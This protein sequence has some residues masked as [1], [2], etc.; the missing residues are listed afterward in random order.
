MPAGEVDFIALKRKTLVFVEVKARSVS[1]DLY[2]SYG[3]PASAVDRQ[4]QK[5]TVK[6]A[7]AYISTCKRRDAAKQPR[8]DVLEVWLN[9]DHKVIDINHITNAYC[10][11]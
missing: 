4:K 7:Q 2:L 9:E 8:M 3:S 6:A 5:R 11:R 10:A 1:E